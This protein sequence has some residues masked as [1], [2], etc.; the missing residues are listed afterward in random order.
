MRITGGTARGRRLV[1]PRG[2]TVRPTADRVREAI[3]DRLGPLDAASVLDLF[4]GAGALALDALSRGAAR[5]VL[6]DR[7]ARA[8]EACRRN[9][10]ALGLPRGAARVLRADAFAFLRARGRGLGADLVFLDPPYDFDRWDPLLARLRDCQAVRPGGIVV[11]ER[12]VRADPGVPPGYRAERSARYGD[13]VVDFLVAGDSR[14]DV[15]AAPGAPPENDVQR[16]ALYPGSF[17]P[18]TNGH[19]GLIRRGLR[20]FDGLIVAVAHNAR[21][22]TLFSVEERLEMIRNAVNDD[23]RVE[24]TSFEG[25][26]VDYASRRGVGVVLR[27]LRAVADFEYELQM[28]NMNRKISP[29]VETFFMM[30][31]EDYFFVSSRNVK[32][33]ASL[34]GPVTSLVPAGVERRL[35]E[36]FGFEPSGE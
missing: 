31:Q 32:E 34:G 29:H 25:L 10:E 18:I 27:G 11:R 22:S 16:V 28:A 13:T 17:D 3:F 2:R 30:T 36:K 12:S 6:V 24:I 4:A 23:P 14:A 7:D 8:V 20:C 9:A 15:D 1:A 26:L 33:I 35:R 21:K 19:V 5:A